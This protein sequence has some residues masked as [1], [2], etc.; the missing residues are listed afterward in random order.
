M[1]ILNRFLYISKKTGDNENKNIIINAVSRP[2]GRCLKSNIIH[3]ITN[4]IENTICNSQMKMILVNKNIIMNKNNRN[5]II[6]DNIFIVNIIE[7]LK[8]SSKNDLT[9]KIFSEI[10]INTLQSIQIKENIITLEKITKLFEELV[11]SIKYIIAN[12]YY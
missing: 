11:I 9:F 8:E 10:F 2:Y 3:N 12:Y 4:Y 7:A 5:N 6:F 1:S